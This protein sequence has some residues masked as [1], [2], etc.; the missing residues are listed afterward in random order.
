MR[1]P[2]SRPSAAEAPPPSCVTRILRV[3]ADGDGIG[4]ADGSAPFYIPAVL[5]GELV[6]ARPLAR[7]G[8]GWACEAE[9][10][11]GP[12]P[13]R[14]DPP[15][16]HFG[17]CGGCTLQHWRAGA[18]L[19]WKTGLLRAALARAGYPDARIGTISCEPGTRR[20]MDLAI[21]REG[22]AIRLGLHRAR[23]GEIIDLATC[24]VAAPA[25]VDLLAPL[26]AALAG[27]DLLRREGSAVLNLLDAGP[28]LLLRT[29]AEPSS[30][31]RASLAAFA[32][33]HGLPRIS[34]AK[35][36]GAR[37][38]G[39][40]ETLCLLRP[41]ATMLGN[42]AVEPPPGA[43][44]QA[45]AAGEAAIR[46]S[47]L[48]GLGTKLPGRARVAELYAG[49]GTLTFPLAA[50][51]RVLAVEG[52]ASAH[53]ALRGAA[54]RAGLSGRVEAVQRDLARQPMQA[55][56]LSGFA[57]I[58]LD[59]PFAGAAAQMP[60]LAASG[61]RRVIYVSCN[62]AALS[63]DAAVLRRAGYRLEQASA[64]DQFL[65]SARLEAVTVFAR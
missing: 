25:L 54:G 4:Q 45:S 6:R 38:S 2:A 63:R 51:C 24:L 9:A 34:W 49:C 40:A 61:V 39:P 7:R 60:P 29:D 31:D 1:R 3:G 47:V 15:C 5:P 41:P 46:E 28:D 11:I 35:A 19:D 62:P 58:V 30:A 33:A 65:W 64:I 20:R 36:N 55:A 8:E 27:L 18:Y 17:A 37:G 52:D 26:R 44:L 32:R 14:V 56:E 50:R 59:P 57:A 13:D 42:V 12:S 16:P 43:F 48:A 21:R 22:G 10:L 53:A 23:G